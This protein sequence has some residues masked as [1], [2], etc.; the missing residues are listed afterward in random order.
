M[1]GPGD[2]PIHGVCRGDLPGLSD[3][4]ALALWRS[5]EVTGTREQM[6]GL[7]HTFENHPLLIQALAAKVA[8]DRQHPR[9]FDA[10]RVA[11][12]LFNPFSLDM[13]HV[14][15]HILETAMTGLSEPEA[16]ALHVIAAFRLPAGYDT[17]CALLIGDESR[18]CEDQAGLIAALADLEDRGLLGWDNRPGVNRYD[19]HPIVRGVTWSDVS[20][21]ARQAI[22]GTLEVHFRAMP[23]VEDWKQVESLE[24]LTPAIELYDK[25]IG[26]QRYDDAYHL[27]CGRLEDATLYRLSANRQRVELL[28]QL[29][30]DGTDALP[31]LSSA[32]EQGLALGAL[33]LAYDLAG[34]PGAAVP[35]Y[36]RSADIDR[37]EDDEAELAIVLCNL[38]DALRLSGGVQSAETSAREALVIARKQDNRF[39]EGVSLYLLGLALATRGV[40]DYADT[41]L[42]RSLRI[43]SAAENRQAEGLVNGCLAEVALGDGDPI[44]ARP[45][46]DQ[47]WE[48]A[49]V[50]RA[51]GDFICAART[52]GTAALFLGGPGDSDI[53][54]ERLHHALTRA[55]AC[56]LVH[57]ELPALVA[58]AEL[59][60]RR[61]EPKTAR[62]LLEDVWDPA[63]RGP[64]PMFHADGLNVLAQI[65][66][67][68]G[69]NDAA[70]AAAT[71]AYKLAWCDGPPFAYHWGLE[72][73]RKHLA[74]LG[75]AAPDLPPFVEPEDDSMPEVEIN[76]PDEFAG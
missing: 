37:R 45:L 42:R 28:K 74:E 3:D 58:L 34:Q 75:A 38:A 46:A 5:F 49:A 43:Y 52:Q 31:R 70:V 51:E 1:E 56:N 68:A 7:F 14:K 21:D 59:H 55:R 71:K 2:Q 41:A 26:L 29:F 19:L 22:Y 30:P 23:T 6:L 16:Y 66:R 60:R 76:P 25:L 53:A 13:T 20:D 17:L 36:R 54:D 44:A 65:E 62:E 27:F 40:T 35:V 11:N 69:N 47:A 24:D 63:E 32:R 67:D 72:R 39:Q 48:L 10:W 8:H 64:Y 15:A 73:A 9:D 4:D 12:P 61:E 57:E 50:Q 18:Q 33:A